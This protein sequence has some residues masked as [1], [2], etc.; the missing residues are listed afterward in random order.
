MTSSPTRYFFTRTSDSSE[1]SLAILAFASPSEECAA[2]TSGL[3]PV[4]CVASVMTPQ[5]VYF[6]RLRTRTQCSAGLGVSTQRTAK[7]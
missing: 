3:R 6:T 1:P 2:G 7:R 5:T 4:T